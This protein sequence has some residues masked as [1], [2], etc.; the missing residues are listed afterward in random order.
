MK[1][2]ATG[3]DVAALGIPPGPAIGQLLRELRAAQASGQV[4]S[5]AGALRWLAGAVA[6]SR[7]RRERMLTRPGKRGG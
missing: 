3:D 1:P 5:R 4:R 6:R 7:D 2:I